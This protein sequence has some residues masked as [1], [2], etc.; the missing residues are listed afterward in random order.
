MSRFHLIAALFATLLGGAFYRLYFTEQEPEARWDI[1]LDREMALQ[2]ARQEARGLGADVSGWPATIELAYNQN[3]HYWNHTQPDE[4]VTAM[5]NPLTVRV[6]FSKTGARRTLPKKKAR[7]RDDDEDDPD[8]ALPPGLPFAL[9]RA[10]KVSV[11]LSANG[12]L[13]HFE[14]EGSSGTSGAVPNYPIAEALFRHITG[15]SAPLF[16]PVTKGDTLKEGIYYAWEMQK[17]W[18]G[19]SPGA[20]FRVGITMVGT[21]V[22]EATLS[23][24]FSDAFRKEADSHLEVLAGFRQA[25]QVLMTVFSSIALIW[26]AGAALRNLADYRFA[27]GL[28]IYTAIAIAV[29]IVLSA[30]PKGFGP[31]LVFTAALPA[32]P[33]I[34]LAGAGQLCA[35]LRERNQW[36]DFLATFRGRILSRRAAAAFAAA[37]LFSPLAAFLPHA[38]AHWSANATVFLR[39]FPDPAIDP[40]ILAIQPALRRLLPSPGPEVILPFFFLL[41]LIGRVTANR[42]L[43]WLLQWGTLFLVFT[44]ISSFASGN[45]AVGF[46]AFLAALLGSFL[47]HQYGV[48]TAVATFALGY[49]IRL[50]AI[51]NLT[52]SGFLHLAATEILLIYAALLLGATLI[53]W[54]GVQLSEAEIEA[55]F[56]R[57]VYLTDRERLKSEFSQA[58][59][60]QQRMLPSRPPA[61]PGFSLSAACKPAKDVGGDLFDYFHLADG[62]LGVCV[63]DVSGKG[64]AA[65]LYMTLTKG[66]LTA[67]TSASGNI[68]DLTK[69]LNTHLYSACRRKM[70]VTAILGALDPPSRTV[71]IVRAGHNPA[72]LRR[73]A[74]GAVEFL[75]PKGVGLGLAGTRIMGRGLEI[76]R[77]TLEP[78]DS[79]IL[80]SDGITEAMNSQKEQYG[81]ERLKAV[82][83]RSP[84][85]RAHELRERIQVDVAAFVGDSPPHDDA[86]VL[87][88][89]CEALKNRG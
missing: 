76:E 53:A 75:Q 35:R 34:A 62:R 39:P 72:L 14:S 58:H 64:M 80:Y 69:H 47:Y 50:A 84:G 27:L 4:P 65:A 10:G 30:D 16:A 37:L 6:T 78:G 88:L 38:V 49:G 22:R 42:A 18:N 21:E 48:L 74:T 77:V 23:R 7:S 17:P 45:A 59:E 19:V 13:L 8:E 29:R 15:D 41:P 33:V 82:V 60:A 86:T 3:L 83:A 85:L 71:E 66:V 11:H 81:D 73:A 79:L 26:Y 12:S 52:E 32:L 20:T 36:L 63:A 87:V 28:G 46:F 40:S 67:A 51:F 56:G 2:L 25:Y 68:L 55:S 31:N 44:L 43:R 54:R 61:V 24:E 57:G 9:G 1:R 89:V 5:T 70:F